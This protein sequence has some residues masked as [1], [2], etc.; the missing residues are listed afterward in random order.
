MLIIAFFFVTV[1]NHK[2]E[3]QAFSRN[4]SQ[5]KRQQDRSTTGRKAIRQERKITQEKYPDA[6]DIVEPPARGNP[7]AKTSNKEEAAKTEKNKKNRKAKRRARKLGDSCR[8]KL[9]ASHRPL[10][11][12]WSP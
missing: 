11:E 9:T 2:H 7:K 12:L 1:K 8:G 10:R 5:G 4:N 6:A 3:V